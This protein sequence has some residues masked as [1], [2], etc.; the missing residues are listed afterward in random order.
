MSLPNSELV[1]SYFPYCSPWP[2][3]ISFYKPLYF[4]LD[5]HLF[6]SI[7]WNENIID[8]L[9]GTPGEAAVGAHP[10]Q[11]REK[12]QEYWL[13]LREPVRVFEFLSTLV[14]SKDLFLHLGEV[15]AFKNNIHEELY[16]RPFLIAVDTLD[17]LNIALEE[18]RP[19]ILPLA[20]RAISNYLKNKN[21]EKYKEE[22][23]RFSKW[24]RSSSRYDR[25]LEKEALYRM[26]LTKKSTGDLEV[27]RGDKTNL[28]IF[29]LVYKLDQEETKS[30]IIALEE[31]LLN[32]SA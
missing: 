13:W 16:N 28:E 31:R 22:A 21:N 7:S 25:D 10:A 29:C 19:V 24:L 6:H 32:L 15:K 9:V 5:N 4:N 11:L 1:A 26:F 3:G 20:D 27:K 14:I 12:N 8:Y 18:T 2:L 23:E 17:G 30:E